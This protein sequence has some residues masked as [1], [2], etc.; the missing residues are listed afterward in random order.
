[1]QATKRA[2]LQSSLQ[3]KLYQLLVCTAR[4]RSQNVSCAGSSR[5]RQLLGTHTDP[6][7]RRIAPIPRSEELQA[8]KRTYDCRPAVT[9][10]AATHMHQPDAKKKNSLACHPR[11]VTGSR[12]PPELAHHCCRHVGATLLSGMSLVNFQ[13]SPQNYL[14][15]QTALLFWLDLHFPA[16]EEIH[17]TQVYPTAFRKLI[18]GYSEGLCDKRAVS[19]AMYI[20]N[21]RNSL[22]QSLAQ[23]LP[24][25]QRLKS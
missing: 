1:V 12:A 18:T 16:T 19:P 22:S 25:N 8:A 4:P 17:N 3:R 23:N 15:S 24:P 2:R 20:N 11:S 5:T 10:T 7:I 6:E 9:V 13:L 14:C 21:P